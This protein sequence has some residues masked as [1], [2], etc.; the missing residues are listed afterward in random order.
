MKKFILSLLLGSFI[1]FAQAQ[2]SVFCYDESG[3][4]IYLKK[5]NNV[6]FI[7]FSNISAT[8][9]N[10]I[11]QQL[12]LQNIR[13]EALTPLI[14]KISGNFQQE[15][16]KNLL[17]AGKIDSNIL[18]IS[19]MLRYKDSTIHWESDAIIV[20]IFP[21]TELSGLLANNHIPYR[22]IKRLGSNPQIFI[23]SLDISE[24]SSI[25]Y[26][27]NLVENN[28]V[29]AAQ[30]SFWSLTR[31]HSF[32]FS[33]QWGMQNTGQYDG[34]SGIDIK[35]PAAWTFATGEGIKVGLIDDGVDLGHPS[36]APNLLPG[37]DASGGGDGAVNGGYGGLHPTKDSHGTACAGQIASSDSIRGVAYN[38]KIIPIR[39]GYG[40]ITGFGMITNPTSD[41]EAIQ[42]A[43]K[44]GADVLSCSWG[45]G[46][47]NVAINSEIDSAVMR[48]RGNKG[49]VVVFS[50]GNDTTAVTY[51]ANLPN[52]IAVGAVSP[53][54]E[55]KTPS[56]C[57]NEIRWGSN[58]GYS[59]NVMAPGVLIATTDLQGNAGVNPNIPYHLIEAS[60]LTRKISL[61]FPNQDYTVWFN[62]SSISAPQIAGIAALVLSVN[63][64]LTSSQVKNIIECT[65]QKTGGYDY[66]NFTQYPNGKFHPEM[67]YGL[68]SAGA[69]VQAAVYGKS[70]DLMLRD[71][72]HDAGVE[73]NY[74]SE[75]G[76]SPDIWIRNTNDSLFEHQDLI[77]NRTNYIY[78]RVKNIGNQPSIGNEKLK[79]YW[80][81][82]DVNMA[83]PTHWN[84]SD[85]LL[86][87][88]IDS[89]TL[90]IISGCGDEVILEFPWNT[91]LNPANYFNTSGNPWQFSLMAR[92]ESSIDTMIFP[93]ITN[94]DSNVRKNNNIAYRNVDVSRIDLFVRDNPVDTGAEPNSYSPSV[95]QT[96]DSPDIWVRHVQDDSLT[97][98]NPIPDD[99]NYVY[100]KITNKGAISQGDEV[101]KLYWSKAGTSLAWDSCWS[102]KHFPQTGSP[103][104]GN[105]IDSIILP[106][107]PCQDEITVVIPWYAPNPNDYCGTG[108]NNN[109]RDFHLLARIVSEHDIMTFP[110]TTKIDSNIRNNNNIAM[111]RVNFFRGNLM[112]SNTVSDIG[113]KPD[114]NAIVWESP[115][116]WVCHYVEG[117][118][119]NPQIEH[120]PVAKRSNKVYVRVKNTGCVASQGN[121][122]LKLYWAKV[123]TSSLPWSHHWDGSNP[124]L[125][126]FIGSAIIPSI[127]P[128]KTDK[129]QINWIAP[130]PA[131][132]SGYDNPFQFSLLARIEE[133]GNPIAALETEDLE[134]N[135]RN[136]KNIAWKNVTVA[137]TLDLMVRDNLADTGTEP[138]PYTGNLWDSP[139]I[140]CRRTHDHG[141]IHQNPL[142]NSSFLD[143]YV[144][145]TNKSNRFC[146]DQEATISLYWA[147]KGMADMSHWDK[148]SWNLIE[149]IDRY[150]FIESG[151]E[152]VFNFAWE[153]PNLADYEGIVD[154]EYFYLLAVIESDE[155]DFIIYGGNIPDKIKNNN[156][157]AG[158]L[159][160]FEDRVD[161]IDLMIR[162]NVNDVG[163]EPNFS[164]GMMHNS[165]DI[166][167]R[168]SPDGQSGHENPIGGDTNYVH[169]HVKSIGQ[170][171]SQ[172]NEALY[173]YWSKASTSISWPEQW[174][175]TDSIGGVPMGSIIGNL[176]IPQLSP[177]EDTILYLPWHVPDIADYSNITTE[178]WHF[179]LLARI[180]APNSDP[181]TFEE[182]RNIYGNTMNN[183]NIASRNIS[184][185][186]VDQTKSSAVGVRGI[187]GQRFCLQFKT[188]TGSA[189]IVTES[190]IKVKLNNVLYQAWQNGG[191]KGNGIERIGDQSILVKAAN[192]NLCNLT[193]APEE[194]GMLSMQFNFLTRKLTNQT[195][196]TIHVI[197][198]DSIMNN[199]I[200]GEVY[201]VI[202][203][204]RT[205]FYANAGGDIYAYPN[206]TIWLNAVSI[207]EPATYNWY[208][209]S[210]A[211][212][213]TGMSF[214]TSAVIGQKY[215]LEVIAL[216]DGYKDYAEVEI[217][218]NYTVEEDPP[219]LVMLNLPSLFGDPAYEYEY[220]QNCYEA[221]IEPPLNFDIYDWNNSRNWLW[222]SPDI[223][224]RHSPDG[225]MEHQN[226]QLG[227]NYVYIRIRNFGETSTGEEQ[228]TLYW[229]RA[230]T[231]LAWIRE[232]SLTNP[233]YEAGSMADKIID[234]VTI[235]SIPAGEEAIIE[236][237][238][239]IP[240]PD[241]N[242]SN[243]WEEQ[244]YW[245]FGL[246]WNF[247]LL[248]V[249]DDNYSTLAFS[250][251]NDLY[252][253]VATSNKIVLKNR[254][255]LEGKNARETL[256]IGS[257]DGMDGQPFDLVIITDYAI[258][259]TG[260]IIRL[261]PILYDAWQRGGGDNENIID[262]GDESFIIHGG[263]GKL[264]NIYF[265]P[266][267]L[268]LL[269]LQF[270]FDQPAY[271]S[272][273]QINATSGEIIGGKTFQVNETHRFYSFQANAGKDIYADKGE[274]I[275]LNAEEVDEPALYN[276][277]DQNDSLI[278]EGISFMT[279]VSMAQKY[280]LEVVAL[281][282]GF[283]D[284]AE[285]NVKLKPN[286]IVSIYPNPASNDIMVSYKLNEAETA[287]I[288]VSNYY[289]TGL[290]DNYILD[291]NSQSKM[292][293]V[294]RYTTGVYV[295]TLICDGVVA[296]IKTFIKQ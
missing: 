220:Y 35:A 238:W 82:T 146:F 226:P 134:R 268:G 34:I 115:D 149:T 113:I 236:I 65:A 63:P 142:S 51:P 57:D 75:I 240:Y 292:L 46:V 39:R 156:N 150:Y 110:E 176:T 112:I 25:E 180:V 286:K 74:I 183:N 219:G 60:V 101:L 225:E 227:T 270:H 241:F 40:D 250:E 137:N 151:I 104:M 99:T 217:R 224:I 36:L 144:R 175:G 165:P 106:V 61:D 108:N 267:E 102:G 161:K 98:Q 59:L 235:P 260:I 86:G 166:W 294:N 228:L 205:P 192:A 213:H 164:N 247:G 278:Y 231:N 239:E 129:I 53:C 18:Y 56:S 80:G 287:Y 94:V 193:L 293:S 123:D 237:P 109:I 245:D 89:V 194:L 198:T 127:A 295:V 29:I 195:N 2:D 168:H 54:G 120:D 233:F 14:H 128:N 19:D 261:D 92:I 103:L 163:A 58:Y 96:W 283:K 277:Y 41:V 189:N 11:L 162:D 135:V 173:F 169:V 45:G 28:A 44:N 214:S 22:E 172:G 24:Q 90:P 280:K 9:G 170:Y 206:E 23:I 47:S 107:I 160:T 188:E 70:I 216:S 212:I 87:K 285:V 95:G 178:P 184:V 133:N 4:K 244:P 31:P 269:D 259:E 279:S 105:L 218:Q 223:W 257:I 186:K 73:P 272:V 222:D 246:L 30:P 254:S 275:Q 229:E 124:A 5:E 289:F 190:E 201:S 84:G 242:D 126:N 88:L 252:Y 79:L 6:K 71:D 139:D 1:V 209:T 179:C 130:D 13:T 248:A 43:W 81:K 117:A 72:V 77:A 171:T 143:V 181:M 177:G 50:V 83:W 100:V 48:G 243:P 76:N 290:Y 274:M 153:L 232:H 93:E 97:H 152:E 157:I 182:T 185:L 273:F 167:V 69:A 281:A 111:K 32:Y 159:I 52:V 67:G 196:F 251:T 187:S 148:E 27:N 8:Q 284:S 38:A 122:V 138:N 3:E 118:C 145:V 174:D 211:L 202:K 256:G 155:G 271:C 208:N 147:N 266:H 263:V 136:N 191:Y 66:Q 221:G 296:D 258:P 17:L 21:N 55:R 291:V 215:K 85:T 197:Q 20:K 265:E 264:K 119:D 230:A 68:A 255:V 37:Y 16:V 207:N 131:N 78:V 33:S 49:C 114:T 200:G 7:H 26:A 62:G 140:W 234:I 64:N 253:N 249:I 121:E 154:S 158:Q 199:I 141:T 204:N 91:I 125:G 262:M 210:G 282:D 42:W 15:L 203:S 288:S 132:Y 10:S 12:E 116:I 276:W